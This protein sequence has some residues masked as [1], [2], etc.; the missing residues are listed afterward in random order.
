MLCGVPEGAPRPTPSVKT[1]KTGDVRAFQA[2][3]GGVRHDVAFSFDAVSKRLKELAFLNKGL[4]IV[5]V[6][7]RVRR[8][9]ESPSCVDYK[10]DGGLHDFCAVPQRGEER[11]CIREPVGYKTEKEGIL[12]EFAIQHTGDF[13]ESLF[14][15]VNNIPT[16]EGG[17]HETGFRAGADQEPQRH[18]ALLRARSKRRTPTCWARTS[19]RG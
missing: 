5:L 2:G 15:F 7:E 12:I 13:T 3:R 16:P 14:S 17:F 9:A 11:R 18:R 4:E 6:D 8:G 19:A 10:F 1:D